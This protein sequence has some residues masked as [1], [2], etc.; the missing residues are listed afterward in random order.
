LGW[1]WRW[2]EGRRNEKTT[3]T[4]NGSGGGEYFSIPEGVPGVAETNFNNRA[5]SIMVCCPARSAV[6]YARVEE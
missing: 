4:S 1:S 5:H 6:V 3:S 2:R